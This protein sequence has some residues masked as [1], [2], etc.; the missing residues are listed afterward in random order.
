MSLRE[1]IKKSFKKEEIKPTSTVSIV[2]NTFDNGENLPKI[3]FDGRNS[4]IALG[5]WMGMLKSVKVKGALG[6]E[7]HEHLSATE[8]DQNEAVSADELREASIEFAKLLIQTGIDQDETIVI[9]DF[10]EEK[11]TFKCHLLNADKDFDIDYRYGSFLDEGPSFTITEGENVTK[12]DYVYAWDEKP[13][14]LEMSSYTRVNPTTGVKYWFYESEY[15]LAC[16]LTDG[17]YQLSIHI[18]YP[19]SL[20][21]NENK[22][23]NLEQLRTSLMAIRLPQ[24]ADEMFKLVQSSMLCE[25]NQFPSIE[26]KEVKE[27][28]N[29]EQETVKEETTNFIKLTKGKLEKFTITKDNHTISLNANNNSWSHKDQTMLLSEDSQGY[30]SYQATSI[31]NENLALIN[32]GAEYEHA[33]ENVKELSDYTLSL[34]KQNN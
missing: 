2:D 6:I 12:Y 34:F 19:E 3:T 32:I 29:E 25:F 14:Y 15:F 8:L 28:K 7:I 16:T 1:K 10:D 27:S 20:T 33:K 17:N 24:S 21:N 30:V 13:R 5:Q 22:Y 23:F 9:S 18:E 11:G 31:L 4:L 26:I